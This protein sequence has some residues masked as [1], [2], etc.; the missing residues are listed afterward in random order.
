MALPSFRIFGIDVVNEL[1]N[2]GAIALGAVAIGKF[3]D[4]VKGWISNFVPADYVDVASSVLIGLGLV[5]LGYNYGGRY[6]KYIVLAGEGAISVG[7]Y[8]L[9]SRGG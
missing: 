8:E 6:S 9:M 1:L 7:L 2:G 5:W 4:Q 3:G